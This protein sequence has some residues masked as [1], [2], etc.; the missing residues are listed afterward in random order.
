MVAPSKNRA[1]GDIGKGRVSKSGQVTIPVEIRHELGLHAGD[2]VI[3]GR[4]EDGKITIRKPRSAAQ[5]AGIAGPRPKDI[6]VD[7]LIR[8]AT[9][10]GMERRTE[11]WL[12]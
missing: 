9:H 11:R 12:K 6:S 1:S 4:G 7:E 5:L 10:E 2:T 3:Y 8:E